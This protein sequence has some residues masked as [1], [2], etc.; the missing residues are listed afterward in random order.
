MR[1][2]WQ[3]PRRPHERRRTSRRPV[4]QE[5]ATE[6]A[7]FA[8]TRVG[9]PETS[10][11]R[12]GAFQKGVGYDG[13]RKSL[14]AQDWFDSSTERDVANLLEDEAEI[15][16][17][18]RLQIGDLP[19]LWTGACEY[20]PDFI[21]IDRAGAHWL[22]EVKMDK[23]LASADVRGK[24]AAARRWANYVSA[25]LDDTT[26][27]Y[28]LVSESDVKTARGAWEALKALGGA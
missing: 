25:A 9:R 7:D 21:A 5:E 23:E 8:K 28:L 15:T 17:W 26:W 20:N 27:S 4:R 16:L 2:R 11:D 18:V 22:I 19:I 14:Y 10:A 13:Y 1:R 24:R 6:L 3:P 12:F